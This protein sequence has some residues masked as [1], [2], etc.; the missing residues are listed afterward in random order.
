MSSMD[1]NEILLRA[2][3]LTGTGIA[4]LPETMVREDIDAGHLT[5]ILTQCTT[6]DAKAEIC[7]FYSHRELLPARIRT[8]VDYCIEFFRSPARYGLRSEDTIAPRKNHSEEYE[9]MSA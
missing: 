4:A 3:A 7:L 2:A 5:H 8:F 1:G 6:S 9:L